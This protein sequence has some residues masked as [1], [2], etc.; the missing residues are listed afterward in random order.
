MGF[1]RP[2]NLLQLSEH[3]SNTYSSMYLFNRGSNQNP[4][5]QGRVAEIGSQAWLA[6]S[7]DLRRLYQLIWVWKILGDKILGIGPLRVK[8]FK[9]YSKFPGKSDS[10]LLYH[11]A[12]PPP[13]PKPLHEYRRHRKKGPS[14]TARQ[15]F[16]WLLSILPSC[17]DHP[18]PLLI[19]QKP[20]KV[21]SELIYS[22]CF[23]RLLG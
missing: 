17:L 14:G 12:C 18:S 16:I 10:S 21:S 5:C 22:L 6:V 13:R 20:I 19:L 23:N 2:R 11:S 3:G 1:H 7:F 4:R 8:N 15:L 9:N